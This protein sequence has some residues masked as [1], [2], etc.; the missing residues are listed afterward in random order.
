MA[1]LARGFCVE[2]PGLVYGAGWGGMAGTLRRLAA[3]RCFP[4][5]A[6]RHG[7]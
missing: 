2:R 4:T 7:L 3:L 1:A 6:R 5:S